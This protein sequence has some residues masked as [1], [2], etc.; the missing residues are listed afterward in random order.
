MHPLPSSL[1]VLQIHDVVLYLLGIGRA[2][3]VEVEL[4]EIVQQLL[5][6]PEEHVEGDDGLDE[7][8]V[9]RSLAEHHSVRMVGHEVDRLLGEHL[10]HRCDALLPV[11]GEEHDRPHPDPV[12]EIP[13]QVRPGHAAAAED[14]LPVPA[15]EMRRED[16][17][18]AAP[19]IEDG[20]VKALGPVEDAVVVDDWVVPLAPLDGREHH[21]ETVALLYGAALVMAA[22]GVA[23][24]L[25]HGGAELAET[26]VQRAYRVQVVLVE[27]L[28]DLPEGHRIYYHGAESEKRGRVNS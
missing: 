3:G 18:V 13:D 27:L 1:I 10:V 14:P 5:L 28:V 25:Q 17:R 16:E 22:D 23:A 6:V 8:D 7:V 20:A 4:E 2:D 19:G 9:V 15:E 12:H 26:V 11:L 21:P 24:G